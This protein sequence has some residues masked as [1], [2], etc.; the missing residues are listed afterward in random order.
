MRRSLN[1]WLMTALSMGGNTSTIAKTSL[2]YFRT[3]DFSFSV[4]LKKAKVKSQIIAKMFFG[5]RVLVF[6]VKR[7][8]SYKEAD[9]I[10]NILLSATYER[11]LEGN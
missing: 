11:L 8:E 1:I 9:K 7:F 2:A 3:I 10:T 5:K 4:Q 6:I